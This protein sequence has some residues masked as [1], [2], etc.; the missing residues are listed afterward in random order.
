MDHRTVKL[1]RIAREFS[2]FPIYF[3]RR[4]RTVTFF[5]ND[6]DYFNFFIF[7]KLPEV[8]KSKIDVITQIITIRN[9]ES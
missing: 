3:Q 6:F 8:G 9:N 7:R 1:N 5:P 4:I 2:H